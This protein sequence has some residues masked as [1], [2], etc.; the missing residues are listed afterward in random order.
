M[1][2]RIV[3]EHDEMGEICWEIQKRGIFGWHN[4]FPSLCEIPE[5]V[6]YDKNEAFERFNRLNEFDNLRQLRRNAKR[7]IAIA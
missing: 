2:R 4:E 7:T 6:F 5:R 1:R 3:E